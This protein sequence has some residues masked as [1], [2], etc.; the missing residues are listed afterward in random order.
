MATV[1]AYQVK[2]PENYAVVQFNLNGKV[3]NIIEPEIPKASMY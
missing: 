3:K 1:F 2:N